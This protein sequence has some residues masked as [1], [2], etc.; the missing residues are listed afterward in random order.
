MLLARQRRLCCVVLIIDTSDFP[1]IAAVVFKTG[2]TARVE[3]ESAIV[4]Q[5]GARDSA[6]DAQD[7]EVVAHYDDAFFSAV[8]LHDSIQPVPGPARDIRKAFAA[9]NLDLC[10]LGSPFL[11]KLR[12]VFLN[13]CECET[14]QFA[15]IE[16]ANVS[17]DDDRELMV[18]TKKASC[19]LRALQVARVNSMYPFLCQRRGDLFRLADSDFIEIQVRYALAAT[20]QIP[21]RGAVTNQEDLHKGV[22]KNEMNRKEL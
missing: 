19:L 12:V 18:Q 21:I 1:V 13:L 20:L 5:V 16:F 4:V 3:V 14:F 7:R 11:N 6:E 10:R 17:L 15:M 9:W 8:T 2:H 22:L